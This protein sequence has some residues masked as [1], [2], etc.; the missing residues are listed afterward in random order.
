MKPARLLSEPTAREGR[1]IHL[2]DL[3]MA[4]SSHRYVRGST[5]QF[6]RWLEQHNSEPLPTGP[7]IWISGDCHIGNLGPVANAQGHVEIQV[8]DL[9]QTV[10]GNPAHDLLR[11]ALSLAS[12]ARG[13][14]LPG[15]T[16][17]MMMERI[18]EGYEL[19]FEPDFDAETDLLTPPSILAS[20]RTSVH[21]DWK[22]LAR[23]TIIDESPQIPLGKKFW[24]L[25][26]DERESVAAAC[27]SLEVQRLATMRKSRPDDDKVKL[28]DTAFWVKGCSS[29]GKL[30]YVALLSVAGKKKSN[31]PCQRSSYAPR[32]R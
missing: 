6:C 22:T 8:R 11:L 21:A 2:P 19:A 32:Q 13:S 18:L 27:D 16:T 12:A 9:D 10:I 3:Q 24:P 1:L 15:V 17:F 31:S 30:R 14:N 5:A 20:L 26:P 4:E 29:L 28:V 25:S 7:P 23:E